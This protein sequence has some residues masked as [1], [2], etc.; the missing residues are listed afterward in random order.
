MIRTR[1]T[2]LFTSVKFN[3]S[4]RLLGRWSA[5]KGYGEEIALGTGLVLE[6]GVLSATG[7]P[8]PYPETTVLRD[9]AGGA[10]FIEVQVVNLQTA[11]VSWSSFGMKK[12]YWNGTLEFRAPSTLG[13]SNNEYLLVLPQASGTLAT[14][15]DIVA[16]LVLSDPPATFTVASE[17]GSAPSGD[18]FQTT[19]G[20]YGKSYQRQGLFGGLTA[21]LGILED[22]RWGFEVDGGVEVA[23]V[24]T[25]KS[26]PWLVEEWDDATVS[27]SQFAARIGQH[28]IVDETDVYLCV[29]ENPVKW[30]QIY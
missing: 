9:E 20:L 18:Y 11:N 6:N 25:D 24:D 16:P 30:V 27:V 21:I 1:L 8:E 26:E 4:A 19:D 22:G 10:K 13:G 3:R 29:R 14:R 5:G 28:A 23:S 15:D 2:E 7:T 17:N 12:T